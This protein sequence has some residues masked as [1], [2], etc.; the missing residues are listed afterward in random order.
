VGLPSVL[1]PLQARPDSAAVF[2]DFDGTLSP[3]VAD[4]EL[5]R[6][7]PGVP[8]LL[9]KLGRRYAVVAVIS[10]RPPE[11]LERRLGRP[12]GVRLIGLYGLEEVGQPAGPAVDAD[13]LARWRSVMARLAAQAEREAPPGVVVEDKGAGLT[14]HFRQAPAAEAWA[15]RFGAAAA[16]EGVVVQGARMA[17]ELRPA[18]H[19]D[20][21]TVV[22][23]LAAGCAAACYVGDDLGDLAAFEALS[24]LASSGAA[25][26]RVAVR[27][28]ESPPALVEAADLVLESPAA[29][30]RLLE[31]LAV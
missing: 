5:A 11:F 12:H 31:Q 27:D 21:G 25:V 16:A 23:A 7:L 17:V 1:E 18:I 26:A 2:V 22:R 24:E 13:A 28:R 4:P 14:L 3:I 9:G 19:S 10:G 20:K 15:R 8:E 6:P 30:F 29:V